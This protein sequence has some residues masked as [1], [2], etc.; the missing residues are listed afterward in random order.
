MERADP[1]T[2][3][4][5]G[6]QI[7]DDGTG[8]VLLSH[9]QR[10]VVV[11]GPD[12]GLE[13][14]VEATHLT[15]GSSSKNDLVLRDDTVSRRHCEIFVR[16]ERYCIRDLESTNGTYVNGTRVLE[17][18]L[19]P[20]AR[21]TVG[22]TDILFEPKKKWERIAES[23]ADHFGALVGV[24]RS[25]RAVF[26]TLAK[27][28]ATDL[29]CILV[30]ETGT[31][32]ELAARGLHEHSPRASRPFV[33]VD[34]GAVSKTLIESE[35]FGH[36]KGAFTG[37]DR[38]RAGAFE[39]ADGGTIFLDEIGELPLE[40]QPKLLRALERKEVKR[41]GAAR[42]VEVD[43]R[44]VAATHR[45]LQ[46][47]IKRKEFRE[48]LYY[49]LAEVVVELPP[50]RERREDIEVVARRILEEQRREGGRVHA[51]APEALAEL[52]SRAWPGNVRELRNVLRR[53]MAMCSGDTLG[54][55]DLQASS[56]ERTGSTLAPA[57]GPAQGVAVV[58]GQA[59]DVGDGLPIKEAR[60]RWLA[61]MEREYLVR[62]MRRCNGD[63][64]RASAEAGIHRK[65]LERL[66]RQHGLRASDLRGSG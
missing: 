58:G 26:A 50:L 24:S 47:M 55:S 14:E 53:A 2:R 20:G 37:A 9:R 36:E 46:A 29:S 66:L 64:D 6:T 3:T 39:L 35:L 63:L 51:I 30:G 5:R 42:H 1:T 65:S 38:Q 31:G 60:D 52:R 19:Q 48:D 12:R 43:V 11:S 4:F 62:L 54:V 27:V 18:V 15:I 13:R 57:S 32:K 23:D 56:V 45:D 10:L 40:L 17:A 49:R 22:S 61:P 34:C 21:I 16:G 33:I 44:I 28:A 8:P 41:L 25:M 7:K 59:L